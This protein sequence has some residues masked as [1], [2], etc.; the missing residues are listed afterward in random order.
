MTLGN[1][2]TVNPLCRNYTQQN[3]CTSC[4]EGY[5]LTNGNCIVS[6]T[7]KTP[8][9]GDVNCKVRAS[10][11][12]GCLECYPSFYFN[13][14]QGKCVEANPLCR[15]VTNMNKC[16]SCYPGY[17]LD[18]GQGSCVIGNS[19]ADVQVN[20]G[21]GS[22]AGGVTDQ[23]AAILALLSQYFG[24]APPGSNGNFVRQIGNYQVVFNSQ[25]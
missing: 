23:N 2:L 12:A 6:S 10:G 5:N 21:G 15:T 20:T 16:T 11:S 8:D 3:Q 9:A 25:G 17:S 18:V 24:S 14:S 4:Y 13:S 7:F 22:G 19:T 1:C